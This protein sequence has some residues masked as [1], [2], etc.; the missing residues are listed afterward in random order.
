VKQKRA[1]GEMLCALLRAPRTGILP[2]VDMEF[3][4]Y[5]KVADAKPYKGY[6]WDFTCLKSRR[7]LPEDSVR[8]GLVKSL[9]EAYGYHRQQLT[10]EAP[11]WLL[12]RF[13][14]RADVIVWRDTDQEAPFILAEAKA[15]SVG[16]T[17]DH[18]DKLFDY[19]RCFPK[20]MRPRL[21][22]LTN[23][24][25]T[26]V[27][28]TETGDVLETIP[29]L[30]Q[31]VRGFGNIPAIPKHEPF[32][33]PRRNPYQLPSEQVKTRFGGF[34]ELQ[35]AQLNTDTMRAYLSLYELFLDEQTNLSSR[36]M[37][38]AGYSIVKDYGV[39]WSSF[40]N[41]SGG[42]F[43]GR[44]R[45]MRLTTQQGD[46]RN[47]CLSISTYVRNLQR[48]AQGEADCLA[49]IGGLDG[50]QALQIQSDS[51]NHLFDSNFAMLMH[52]GRISLGEGG[53]IGR[54]R[55][56]PFVEMH[57]PAL[58]DNNGLLACRLS[59]ESFTDRNARRL[60]L[61]LGALSDVLDRLRAQVRVERRDG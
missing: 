5:I 20:E 44:Y 15:P 31:A 42:R 1:R 25:Q 49:I 12:G 23:G 9:Q 46:Q 60:V 13:S 61:R 40:G 32:R 55:V 19:S 36:G 14:Y 35:G 7:A 11:L 21:L 10:T 8:F 56:L 38:F 54:A 53:T 37:T 51:S 48:A 39:R 30:R 29:T 17:D 47:F 52:R 58:F 45:H 3:A 2:E 43:Y 27:W 24:V 50:K 6:F 16:L 18:V 22:V 33:R 41:A 26:G 28:D 59:A 4:S 34:D 57:A